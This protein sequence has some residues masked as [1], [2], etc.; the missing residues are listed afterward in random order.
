VIE[1]KTPDE[2]FSQANNIFSLFPWER[3]RIVERD[4][5]LN[6]RIEVEFMGQDGKMQK[7][8]FDKPIR[9]QYLEQTK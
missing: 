2:Y 9:L 5:T 1:Y 7:L 6:A 8:K 4:R 3:I